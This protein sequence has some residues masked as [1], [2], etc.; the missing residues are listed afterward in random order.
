MFRFLHSPYFPMNSN[1]SSESSDSLLGIS[2]QSGDFY[3]AVIYLPS[4][5]TVKS[6]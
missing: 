5:S 1:A 2:I 3:A 4:D 6:L